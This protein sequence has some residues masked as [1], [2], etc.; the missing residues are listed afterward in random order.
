MSRRPRLVGCSL[1]CA[2]IAVA[3]TAPGALMG[4][5]VSLSQL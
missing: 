5:S 3:P 1:V 4:V 2:L